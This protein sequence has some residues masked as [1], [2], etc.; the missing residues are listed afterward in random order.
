MVRLRFSLFFYSLDLVFVVASHMVFGFP[1]VWFQAFV[2]VCLE[3]L[4]LVD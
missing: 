4:G 2:F 1:L 3:V